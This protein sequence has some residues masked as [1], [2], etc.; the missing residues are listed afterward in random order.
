MSKFVHL[1]DAREKPQHC[2]LIKIIKYHGHALLQKKA[3]RRKISLRKGSSYPYS[4]YPGI[5]T[6]LLWQ[7]TENVESTRNIDETLA[8]DTGKVENFHGHVNFDLQYV[9]LDLHYL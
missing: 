4:V 5:R 2:V 7:L 1:D 9:N 8:S 3:I 6:C